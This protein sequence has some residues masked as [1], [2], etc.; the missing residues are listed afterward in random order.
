MQDLCQTSQA[1]RRSSTRLLRV[2]CLQSRRRNPLER[3]QTRD[4]TEVTTAPMI[5]CNATSVIIGVTGQ[6]VYRDAFS[7][8]A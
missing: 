4:G 2:R 1:H 6:V 5:E 8:N 3:R 7:A